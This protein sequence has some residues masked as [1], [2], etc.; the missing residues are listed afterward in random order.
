MLK[1]EDMNKSITRRDSMS[2]KPKNEIINIVYRPPA[3]K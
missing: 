1:T 3:A 2:I